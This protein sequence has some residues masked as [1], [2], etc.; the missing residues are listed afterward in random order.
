MATTRRCMTH[1]FIIDFLFRSVVCCSPLRF[2]ISFRWFIFYFLL[3]AK[4]IAN[5]I[6]QRFVF[7]LVFKH[8]REWKRKKSLERKKA[9]NQPLFWNFQ[10]E[11]EQHWS[12]FGFPFIPF[13]LVCFSGE[14]SMRN[15]HN[16]TKKEFRLF[17]WFQSKREIEELMSHFWAR[18]IFW[19]SPFSTLFSLAKVESF[20]SLPQR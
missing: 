10:I 18:W 12:S 14:Y 9:Q 16:Y 15:V 1:H 19:L 2:C 3:Q 7:R 20:F 4:A 13:V 17:T 6:I 8:K 5:A 11:S